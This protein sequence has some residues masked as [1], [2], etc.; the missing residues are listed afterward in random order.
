MSTRP[1]RLHYTG[2]HGEFFVGVPRRNLDARDIAQLTDAQIAD[3]TAP[4]PATGKPLYVAPEPKKEAP[5]KRTRPPRNRTKKQ[6]PPPP[7]PEAQHEKVPGTNAPEPPAE[8]S[9]E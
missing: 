2:R 7:T 1:E 9:A 8:A 5:P 3:I 6:A 4:N